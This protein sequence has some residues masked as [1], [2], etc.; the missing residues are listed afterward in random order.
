M[1]QLMFENL[2]ELAK[3]VH[4]SH[5]EVREFCKFPNDLKTQEVKKNHINASHL[6]QADKKLVTNK[7]ALFREELVSEA[8]YAH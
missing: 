1:S 6:L 4:E 7:Y 5:S 2:I 8:T 3:N